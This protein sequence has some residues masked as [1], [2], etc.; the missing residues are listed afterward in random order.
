MLT[1]LEINKNQVSNQVYWQVVDQVQYWLAT[2][3]VEIHVH[4]PVWAQVDSLVKHQI[5]IQ[6]KEH[7]NNAY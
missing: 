4:W 1:K 6:A 7:I 2:D 5:W 3:Q